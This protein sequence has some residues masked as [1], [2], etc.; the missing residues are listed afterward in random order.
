MHEPDE[1]ATGHLSTP[2]VSGAHPTT[3]TVKPGVLDAFEARPTERNG[4]RL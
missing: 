2:R 3:G 1:L 4:T